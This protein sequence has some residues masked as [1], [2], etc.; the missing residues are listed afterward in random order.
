MKRLITFACIGVAVSGLA[1]TADGWVEVARSDTRPV[2]VWSVKVGS[3]KVEPGEDKRREIS[4][5]FRTS[6]NKIT[7]IMKAQVSVGA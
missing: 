2:D 6:R 1:Q 4:G 5:V 3:V 7:T